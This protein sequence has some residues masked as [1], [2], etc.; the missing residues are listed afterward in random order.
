MIILG[1]NIIHWII[2]LGGALIHVLLK[3]SEV[4]E[5]KKLLSA[6]TRKD[7]FVSIASFIAIPVLLLVISDTSLSELLPLNYVTSFLLGYQTQSFLRSFI[8]IS[9]KKYLKNENS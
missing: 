6:F 9:S 8:V 3:L 2:A 7:K 4:P 1:I 5:N